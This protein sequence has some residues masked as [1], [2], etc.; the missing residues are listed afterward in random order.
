M[1][2]TFNISLP[3]YFANIVDE[4]IASGKYATRSEFF[5]HVLTIWMENRFDE[6]EAQK[7][8]L[9]HN[10]RKRKIP[11]LATRLP[12]DELQIVEGSDSDEM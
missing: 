12:W 4:E 5:R 7:A 8:R 3:R 2:V 9:A 1:R 6:K 10:L 11:T